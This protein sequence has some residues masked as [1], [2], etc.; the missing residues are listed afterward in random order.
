MGPTV[1]VL[2]H[3]GIGPTLIDFGSNLNRFRQWILHLRRAS[4]RHRVWL[5]L[6]LVIHR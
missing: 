3:V 2:H 1:L 6:N 4:I 5:R